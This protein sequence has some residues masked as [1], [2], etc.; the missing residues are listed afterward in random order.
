MN[1]Q[2]NPYSRSQTSREVPVGM[3]GMPRT[4]RRIWF[5]VAMGCIVP[6]ALIGLLGLAL[7]I[8]VMLYGFM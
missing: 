7:I 4:R 2:P 5:W 6:L 8:Y 1:D 3:D